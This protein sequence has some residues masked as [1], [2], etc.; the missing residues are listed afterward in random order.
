MFLLVN[1][2]PIQSADSIGFWP[3]VSVS[4]DSQNSTIGRPLPQKYLRPI[5]GG[6]RSSNHVETI[7]LLCNRFFVSLERSSDISEI[8]LTLNTI[9]SGAPLGYLQGSTFGWCDSVDLSAKVKVGRLHP[10]RI[11]ERFLLKHTHP[12]CWVH[13]IVL[14]SRSFVLL[15]YVFIW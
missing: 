13:T 3:I 10:S 12:N 8:G 6:R 1:N 5:S 4:A 2:R 11:T 9:N 14:L 7:V 15:K